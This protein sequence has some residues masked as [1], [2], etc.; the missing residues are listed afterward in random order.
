MFVG[1][2]QKRIDIELAKAMQSLGSNGE[3]IQIMGNGPNALDFHISFYI[4]ANTQ[5]PVATVTSI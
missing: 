1:A 4:R 3:Y 2:N 5:K